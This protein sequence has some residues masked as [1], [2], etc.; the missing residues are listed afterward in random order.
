MTRVLIVDDHP[1][2]RSGIRHLL[3]SEDPQMVV[4][5]AESA[6]R[7]IELTTHQV[8][9]LILLDLSLGDDNGIMALRKFRQSHP[10]IPV[11]ILTM[12]TEDQFA[13]QALKNGANGYITKASAPE[14]LWSAV[15]SVLKTGHYRSS[16]QSDRMVTNE[17]MDNPE[18]ILRQLSIRERQVLVGLVSGE[19]LKEIGYRLGITDKSISTYKTRI[20]KKLKI[21]TNAELISFALR[22]HLVERFK[23]VV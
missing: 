5:E 20:F 2:V 17:L 9:D 22:N 12:H 23:N 6:R 16:Q 8:W 19:A 10:T 21:K 7:F 4:D 1:L 11:L 15:Q 13:Q 14:E 18:Q 3:T